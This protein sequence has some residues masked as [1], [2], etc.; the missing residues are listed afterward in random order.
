MK[1]N[2]GK[3]IRELLLLDCSYGEIANATGAAKSTIAYH[4]RCLGIVKRNGGER[5]NWIEIQEHIDSGGDCETSVEKFNLN[6]GAIRYAMKHGLV[7]IPEDKRL[8][9]HGNGGVCGYKIPM[10]EILVENSTY[11]SNTKLKKRLVVEGF[12]KYKCYNE[13]CVLHTHEVL[14]CGDTI[15]LHLDHING[16]RTDNRIKN[17][18]FLCPNCHSQTKTYCGRNK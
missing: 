8:K 9:R 15:V 12:L 7:D 1:H 6:S 5:Y 11:D 13:K 18:R 3:K 10:V 17:L 4:A 16:V 2:K 14:W